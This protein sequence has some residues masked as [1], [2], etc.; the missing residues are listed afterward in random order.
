GP[1]R[2]L[3]WAFGFPGVLAARAQPTIVGGRVF[4]ASETGTVYALDART[5]CTYWT[6]RAEASIRS[7]ITIGPYKPAAGGARYAAYFGDSRANAYAVDA[8]TGQQVWTRKVD[9]HSGA[10]ITGAPTVYE[11]R[12]YVP[13]AGIGAEGAG[14][15]P[16]YE[17]CTF[18]GSVSAIDAS[19]GTVVWKSYSIA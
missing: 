11:S 13:V 5:G 14:S 12:V 10:V 3:R 16:G 15:R 6:F 19:T 7:A 17:C 9:T 8:T 18:R 4:V 1:R 2:K